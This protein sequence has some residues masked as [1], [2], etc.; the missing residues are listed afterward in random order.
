[1]LGAIV[2]ATAAALSI[3]AQIPEVKAPLTRVG[4]AIE[5]TVENA[6]GGRFDP[7]NYSYAAN[8]KPVAFERK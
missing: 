3:G 5:A 1:M 6:T 8:G 7:R 2:I 4:P